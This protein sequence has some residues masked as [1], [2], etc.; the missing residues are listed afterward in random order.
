MEDIL[1]LDSSIYSSVLILCSKASFASNTKNYLHLN[2]SFLSTTSPPKASL[3]SKFLY[4]KDSIFESTSL[5]CNVR[6]LEPNGDIHGNSTKKH[7]CF[8][9]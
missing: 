5:I 9:P 1:A 8:E 4:L 2:T 6:C 3:E 7:S